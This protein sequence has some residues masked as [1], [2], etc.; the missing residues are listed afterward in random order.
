GPERPARAAAGRRPTG[1]R[2]CPRARGFRGRRQ[3]AATAAGVSGACPKTTPR[4]AAAAAGEGRRASIVQAVKA[5]FSRELGKLAGLS[6][7]LISG[8]LAHSG[9]GFTDTVTVGRLGSM[10]L[11]AVA[12]GAS[13]YFFLFIFCSGVLFS[14]APSVS[15]AYGAG[16][17]EGMVLAVRQGVW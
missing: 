13:V 15:Q 8:Q 10:E 17:P 11:A 12:L 1:Q 6:L 3:R 9:V 2:R 16:E 5:R 4:T 7:P 14:V